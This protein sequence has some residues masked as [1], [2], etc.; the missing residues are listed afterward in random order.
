MTHL[1]TRTLTTHRLTLRRF[2]KEDIPA[3]FR[4]WCSDE[5]VT[6]Y[7]R[8]PAHPCEDVTRMVLTD[9]INSY[10]QPDYRIIKY[11]FHNI[12]ILSKKGSVSEKYISNLQSDDNFTGKYRVHPA[13]I[14]AGQERNILIIH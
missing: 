13:E 3:A 11:P 14:H 6:K 10:Q 2:E 8:W 7:L 5:E 9:W 1:G 12:R 4:N